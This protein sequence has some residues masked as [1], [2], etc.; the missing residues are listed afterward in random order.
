MTSIVE[1]I[2]SDY[3]RIAA[4]IFLN[5]YQYR[6]GRA[7]SAR[8]LNDFLIQLS[9][10]LRARGCDIRLPHCWY[11]QGDEVAGSDLPYINWDEN[12]LDQTAVTYCDCRPT[13][14]TADETVA[15][16]RGYTVRF[17]AD[18]PDSD[19]IRVDYRR[20]CE[21][22]PYQFQSEYCEVLSVLDDA[23][24]RSS[25]EIGSLVRSLMDRAFST[26]P[27]AFQTM[28]PQVDEFRVVFTFAIEKQAKVA[29]LMD[30]AEYFWYFFCDHLRLDSRGHDCV[31]QET[32]EIWRSTLPLETA[33][34]EKILENYA[35]H[36]W[37]E[38]STEPCVAALIARRNQRLE[39]LRR[40]LAEMPD[41]D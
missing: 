22:A 34:F 21:N 37:S 5:E 29:E 24:G 38:G 19:E 27:P 8:I 32:L 35:A 41:G 20:I 28:A 30:L 31:S 1:S 16:I 2:G 3:P 39:E 26:F 14:P 40:L 4:F 6:F 15:A 7:P 11:R 23:V 12:Q 33:R 9:Q 25:G 17:M 10:D 36:Y 18:H 13:I